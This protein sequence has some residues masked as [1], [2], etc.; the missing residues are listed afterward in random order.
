MIPYKSWA[1]IPL[2]TSQGSSLAYQTSCQLHEYIEHCQ[3]AK[4]FETC[5]KGKSRKISAA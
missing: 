4:Q 1:H 2:P 5:I 3:N